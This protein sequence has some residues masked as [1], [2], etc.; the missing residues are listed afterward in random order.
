M[1][2]ALRYGLIGLGFF[3]FLFSI[4]LSGLAGRPAQLALRLNV[5]L[6]FPDSDLPIVV[7]GS[8]LAGFSAALEAS[9]L[10]PD[11]KIIILEKRDRWGGN[12]A[13]ASSGINGAGSEIQK[14]AGIAD[15]AESLM[16]NTMRVGH[17]HGHLELVRALAYD[18]A[19]AIRFLTEHGA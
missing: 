10:M 8:G 6:A 16:N 4:L 19:D 15:S 5:P 13:K 9:E 11:R 3:V 12:S 18:S 2:K 17:G 1:G 14:Q 7:V